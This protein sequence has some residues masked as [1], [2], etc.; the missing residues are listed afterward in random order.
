MADAH[1]FECSVCINLMKDPVTIESG[2][3]FCRACIEKWFEENDTCPKT[4]TTLQTKVLCPNHMLR[5][6]IQAHRTNLKRKTTN[7]VEGDDVEPQ[8]KKAKIQQKEVAEK[9][10]LL[11]QQQI[12]NRIKNEIQGREKINF[13]TNLRIESICF[14]DAET[15]KERKIILDEK[16]A[17]QVR[18]QGFDKLVCRFDRELKESQASKIEFR[19]NI[20]LST[21][22]IERL[23]QQLEMAKNAKGRQPTLARGHNVNKKVL[24]QKSPGQSMSR[25]LLGRRY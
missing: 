3:S 6:M 24:Q 1:D 4:N 21:Q 14:S 20:Q 19:R 16:M 8:L 2:H 11:E 18:I 17:L 25:M 10:H 7:D 9:I 15:R 22:I 13:D 12:I 23:K 5:N